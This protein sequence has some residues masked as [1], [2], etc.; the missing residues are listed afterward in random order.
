MQPARAVFQH[1]FE[2][3][4]GPLRVRFEPLRDDAPARGRGFAQLQVA[5][6]LE[7]PPILVTAGPVQQ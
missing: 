7:M 5:N 4:L 3:G 1:E 6:G 2:D